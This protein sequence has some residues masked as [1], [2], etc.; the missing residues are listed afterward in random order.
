MKFRLVCFLCVFL[1]ACASTPKKEYEWLKNGS[2]VS[3]E[4]ISAVKDECQYHQKIKEAS[5]LLGIS[6]SSGRYQSQSSANKPDQY[7]EKSAALI[8]EASDCLR[9]KG[10]TS[11]AKQP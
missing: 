3:K 5:D 9:E 7:I 4:E 10:Y 11:R 8:K 2:V 1:T 6:I